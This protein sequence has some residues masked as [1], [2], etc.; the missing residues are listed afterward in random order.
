MS[1]NSTIED[2]F[3]QNKAVDEM[4]RNYP[5]LLLLCSLMPNLVEGLAIGCYPPFLGS[6]VY[7]FS[8]L[9]FLSPNLRFGWIV[10]V[11]SSSFL[12]S[13]VVDPP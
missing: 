12:D 6:G 10:S 8:E 5:P 11:E 2:T 9:R 7:K 3:S 4:Y 1:L 13:H